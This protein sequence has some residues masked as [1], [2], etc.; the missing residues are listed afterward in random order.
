[1]RPQ[2][3]GTQGR[4]D[5]GTATI[6][7]RRRSLTVGCSHVFEGFAPLRC[8]GPRAL[9]GADHA[10]RPVGKRFRAAHDNNDSGRHDHHGGA[11]DHDNGSSD[12]RAD[13]HDDTS[14]DHDHTSPTDHDHIASHQ[15]NGA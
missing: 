14:G 8:V 10:W 2:A 13:Y 5:A 3:E 1:M 12:N 7:D 15:H 4:R 9:G 11:H 6:P